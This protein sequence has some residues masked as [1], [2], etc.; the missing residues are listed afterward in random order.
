MVLTPVLGDQ[1]LRDALQEFRAVGRPEARCRTGPRPE[2]RR[3][4]DLPFHNRSLSPPGRLDLAPLASK[5]DAEV[6]RFFRSLPGINTKS[7]KCIIMYA[8]DRPVFPV[9][10]HVRRISQ[11]IGFVPPGL[12]EKP[13]RPALR[14]L[15]PGRRPA[16]SRRRWH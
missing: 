10:T 2:G 16:R 13:P 12:S 15:E 14:A 8:M 5:P 3:P 11:R 7:V 4:A 1:A 6:E 9:D